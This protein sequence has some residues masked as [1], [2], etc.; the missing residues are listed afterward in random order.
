MNLH[1]TATWT[2]VFLSLFLAGGI[3]LRAAESSRPNFVLIFTDD[4]GYQDVGCFGSP[5]I[6]TPN[7][8]RMARE[9]MR[10][11]DFYVGQPVCTASRA[12]LLTGCYPNRVG[13]LGALGPRSNI[14]ISDKEW[15]IAQVLKTCGYATAIFGKW[16]LGDSPQFLPTRHGFD[17][18]FGLPYSNDMW[19]YHPTSAKGYPPLPLIRGDKVIGL[20]P[21]QTQ[22]TT[23]YTERAVGFIERNKDRP[24]FLYVAHNM[25]HVP[26]HVSDR[27]KGKSKRGL[28]GDVIMEIDW[29][30]G[31]ILAALK[32][33]GLDEKTVVVFTS[34]NGPWLLYGNH[35]GSALPLR[36]G[37][38]TTFDGGLREP[39][40][41]RWPGKI[42]AGAVC[43]ELAATM[44]LLP[45]F[46]R[47][48]GAEVPRDRIIDGKD[49][50]PLMSGQPGAKTPHD[51]Y[52]YYWG[53][54][55]QAV[56]SGKWKLHLPHNYDHPDPPGHDG[57]PGKYAKREISVALFDLETDIGETNNV[58]DQ[59]PEIVARLQGLAGKCR[60]DLGDSATG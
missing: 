42:P 21:D 13:L 16:H 23:W 25:P 58:A 56:R 40:I 46:A 52:L 48:A 31:Q 45:T 15:T 19:P 53:K 50:W 22:L 59:H 20:M 11:T 37:K 39:C 14:G 38:T 54:H 12:A 5:N 6:K 51:A 27:F 8:D 29:S 1:R 41:M 28:Y 24:F 57:K 9:G 44:D 43:R 47:L 2:G 26:L 10:F 49:I 18:Y 33:N 4:Q 7:L 60:D 3:C 30:V 34:D 35:A 17:E 32:R 55:L 36:E